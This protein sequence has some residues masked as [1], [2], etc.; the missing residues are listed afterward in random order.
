MGLNDADPEIFAHEADAR[1]TG[2]TP[3]E[4]GNHA[5]R[6]CCQVPYGLIRLKR[7]TT[8]LSLFGENGP[9]A[10]DAAGGS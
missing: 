3:V 10:H 2:N 1:P 9:I 8:L 5:K 4:V 6:C 7:S